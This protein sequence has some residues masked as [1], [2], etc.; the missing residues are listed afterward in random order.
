MPPQIPIVILQNL[1]DLITVIFCYCELK[2]RPTMKVRE[3]NSHEVYNLLECL[4]TLAEYHRADYVRN[5]T[6]KSKPLFL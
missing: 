2:R 3:I 6:K 5:L 4:S 1:R